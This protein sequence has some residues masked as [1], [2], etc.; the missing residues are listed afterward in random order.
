MQVGERER[1]GGDLAG[2]RWM[3][4]R[5]GCFCCTGISSLGIAVVTEK[6]DNVLLG[7]GCIDGVL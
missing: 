7:F 1:G 2:E 5:W 4:I 6:K 3:G